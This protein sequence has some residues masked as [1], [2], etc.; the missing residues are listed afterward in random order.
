M[1]SGVNGYAITQ[2]ALEHL[3][4]EFDITIPED[5]NGG[6][7]YVHPRDNETRRD[8]MTEGVDGNY[9]HSKCETSKLT[10]GRDPEHSQ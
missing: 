10:V 4:A 5:C 2:I 6:W 7:F 3:K 8:E 1:V 9:I